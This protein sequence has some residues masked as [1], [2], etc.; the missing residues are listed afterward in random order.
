MRRVFADTA[1]WIALANRRD[2]LHAQAMGMRRLL[3]GATL[4]TTEDVL[5]EFLDH[6]SG[7]GRVMREVAARTVDG[8][9]SDPSMVVLPQS[10]R[11]FLEGL[12]LYKARP[13]K[14]YSLTDCIS[15]EAIRREGIAEVLTHDAHFTQEGF[16]V[17]L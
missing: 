12:A 16:I 4:V 15:M 2:Q 9:L 5:G 3:R 13:D 10:H 14:D 7:G 1:Y 6:F 17:L 11:S 8:I